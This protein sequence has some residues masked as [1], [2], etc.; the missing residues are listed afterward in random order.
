MPS[1]TATAAS[2]TNCSR[3]ENR[4]FSGFKSIIFSDSHFLILQTCILI[5]YTGKGI[6]SRW[7]SGQIPACFRSNTL[8]LPADNCLQ[9]SQAKPHL[10]YTASFRNIRSVRNVCF[11]RQKQQGVR[12][13]KTARPVVPPFRCCKKIIVCGLFFD[14]FALRQKESPFFS[15]RR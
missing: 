6:F 2:L 12:H 9:I 14:N 15:K 11:V 13:N 8:M 1:Q 5:I 7:I 10:S 4:C 3:R